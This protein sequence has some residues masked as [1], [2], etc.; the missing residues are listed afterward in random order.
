MSLEFTILFYILILSIVMFLSIIYKKKQS[1]LSFIIIVL[2][3]SFVAGMRSNTVGIDTEPYRLSIE[4]YI[5]VG[6]QQWPY[7]TFSNFYG[8]FVKMIYSIYHNYNFLLFIEALIINYLIIKRFTDFKDNDKFPIMLFCYLL[9][10]Y[11]KTFNLNVQYIS[12]AIV[13][14]STRYLGKNNIKYFLLTLLASLIH[15]SALISL[16]Y[17]FVTLFFQKKKTKKQLL[18]IFLLLILYLI[19]CN[20]AFNILIDK[21]RYYITYSSSNIGLMVF[22]QLLFYI[23][24]YSLYKKSKNESDMIEFKTISK[25]YLIGILLSFSSYFVGNAGRISYYFMIFEPVY[26]SYFITNNKIDKL[27]KLLAIFWIV[28]YSIYIII[29]MKNG[30]RVF[31]YSFFWN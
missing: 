3:L 2:L 22:V 13:F 23:L 17:F 18:G 4:H 15:T 12:I 11:F 20:Y 16:I 14:Y 28:I 6:S 9:I 10:V 25:Y 8:W 7:V 30:T 21:Y 27:F 5:L 31:P 1:K 29:D 24:T 26:I 19:S